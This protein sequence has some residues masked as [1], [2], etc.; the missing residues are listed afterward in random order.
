MNSYKEY[1]ITA[2]F[3]GSM[4]ACSMRDAGALWSHSD[5]DESMGM[6]FSMLNH[7]W[8]LD[9]SIY[10]DDRDDLFLIPACVT[11][12]EVPEQYLVASEENL[13][14]THDLLIAGQ[15]CVWESSEFDPKYIVQVYAKDTAPEETV[16]VGELNNNLSCVPSNNELKRVK[17]VL[18]RTDL[19]CYLI[20]KLKNSQVFLYMFQKDFVD[21][22]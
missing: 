9:S 11:Y 20:G 13:R 2:L 7:R 10:G 6:Y 4:R 8:L 22:N 3:P 15:C 14:Q 21:S 5:F 19:S 16:F 12:K 1:D 18:N 17:D